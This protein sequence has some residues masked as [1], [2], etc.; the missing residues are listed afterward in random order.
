MRD[1]EDLAASGQGW[2]KDALNVKKSAGHIYFSASGF[3]HD[4]HSRVATDARV[5]LCSLDDLYR[6]PMQLEGVGA[7]AERPGGAGE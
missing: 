5:R 2:A 7:Q 3:S 4:F 1:L 6:R